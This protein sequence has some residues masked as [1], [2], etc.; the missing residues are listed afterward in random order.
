[1]IACAASVPG[2]PGSE[3]SITSRLVAAPAE[4]MPATNRATHTSMTSLRWCRTSSP[5]RRKTNPRIGSR[6]GDGQ[7]PAG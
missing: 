7:Q 4:T 1:M 6:L 2:W 3:K 5:M